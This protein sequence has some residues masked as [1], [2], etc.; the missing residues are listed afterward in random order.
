MDPSHFAPLR[1]TERPAGLTRLLNRLL[2]R[3]DPDDQPLLCAI[4]AA[5]Q[6]HAGPLPWG[7]RRAFSP[8]EQTIADVFAA[9]VEQFELDAAPA[10]ARFYDPLAAEYTVTLPLGSAFWLEGSYGNTLVQNAF[11]TRGWITLLRATDSGAGTT[12]A[13]VRTTAFYCSHP[14]EYVARSVVDILQPALHELR[15]ARPR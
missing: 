13:V 5:I 8:A 10:Y 12:H 15:A 9:V 7:E 6:C 3:L 2:H 1:P 4:A 11:P 14:P